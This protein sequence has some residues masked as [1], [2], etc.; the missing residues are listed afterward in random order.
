M[1]VYAVEPLGR[2]PQDKVAEYVAMADF[3]VL[4]REPAHFANAGFPTKFVESMANGTPVIANLTSDLGLYLQDGVNGL[5]CADHSV[6]AFVATLRRALALTKEQKCGMRNAAR[7]Q[8]EMAFD[9]RGY[10]DELNRFLQSV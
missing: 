2:V 8:A 6:D 1:G 3:S 4:L 10:A 9:F 5:V 7:Q